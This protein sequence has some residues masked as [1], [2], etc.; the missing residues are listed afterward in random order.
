M[1]LLHSPH[2]K[3]TYLDSTRDETTASV[4]RSMIEGPNRDTRTLTPSETP[5][6]SILN[7]LESDCLGTI[8]TGMDSVIS[9][10]TGLLQHAAGLVRSNSTGFFHIVLI[11]GNKR[12]REE[13][14]IGIL[15]VALYLSE[16]GQKRNPKDYSC[17]CSCVCFKRELKCPHVTTALTTT[18]AK[19]KLWT[20]VHRT[21]S[22]SRA[23]T[24]DEQWE[25]VLLPFQEGDSCTVWH[26]FRCSY[27]QI[28]RGSFA[29]VTYDERD[30]RVRL[31]PTLKVICKSCA[32]ATRN[33]LLCTHEKV[34]LE[35]VQRNSKVQRNVQEVEE[36]N[37]YDIE[38]QEEVPENT[39][40]QENPQTS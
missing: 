11:I 8:Q 1:A 36:R 22:Q 40:R 4:P 26:V 38:V 18:K 5:V 39:R 25:G 32:G 14:S 37:G 13:Y 20:F 16:E 17:V 2:Q 7:Q 12:R 19:E 28:R 6:A 21:V 35:L 31:R 15:S 3:L 24:R 10:H 34:C 23:V 29:T 9:S 30:S 33:R 27:L